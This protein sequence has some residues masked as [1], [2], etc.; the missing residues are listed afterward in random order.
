MGCCTRSLQTAKGKQ[1]IN[2]D[3]ILQLLAARKKPK[4][5]AVIHCKGHEKMKDIIVRGNQE[6]GKA[7]KV[8]TESATW[9]NTDLVKT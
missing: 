9:G 3:E 4:K 1:I 7:A 5:V 2:R 6:V 8:A